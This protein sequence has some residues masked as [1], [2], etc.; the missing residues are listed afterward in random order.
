VR[1]D[2]KDHLTKLV[3][4]DGQLDASC[5]SH[6][7][8]I[9][10][11]KNGNYVVRFIYDGVSYIFKPCST[12]A[13]CREQWAQQYLIPSIMEVKAPLLLASGGTQDP[14]LDWII[15]EDLGSLVHCNNA[16]DIIR[17]AGIIPSWHR[18]PTDRML[19]GMMGHS[20]SYSEALKVISIK[21]DSVNEILAANGV[22]ISNIS[23]WW[24]QL[25]NWE[26]LI[27][28]HQVVSHGD[29]YP[30]NI[31]LQDEQSIVLDWEYVHVNSMY[32]DLYS[33]MDITSHRYSRI[34]L[35]HSD[36]EAALHQYWVGMD[37]II[38]TEQYNDFIQ[39]YYIFASV[40]STWI[41]TLIE[42]DLRQST[43]SADALIR[44]QQESLMV[45]QQ[46][47]QGLN[48]IL[49]IKNLEE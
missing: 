49:N 20:P 11:T 40:Y 36:R 17:A 2:L 19:K 33:L 44:Q 42:A 15:Y 48:I 10:T 47:L 16:D 18:I 46:C 26:W 23:S 12:A 31:A 8:T 41:L 6:K 37:S 32:W 27:Q 25:P 4:L 34:P 38:P 24:A 30:L 39:G 29:Y 35:S 9:Y 14:T 7:E 3:K 22:S 1:V 45:F 43:V 13:A 28:D 5:I 21:P